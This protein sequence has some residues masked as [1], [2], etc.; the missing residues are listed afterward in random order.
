[1]TPLS[2]L[3]NNLIE[4]ASVQCEA[5]SLVTSF[6]GK[7]LYSSRSFMGLIFRL[8]TSKEKRTLKVERA[9]RE[10][11]E[12]FWNVAGEL[13]ECRT[14]YQLEKR[15]KFNKEIYDL[16]ALEQAEKV[17]LKA[18]MH[19]KP[20]FKCAEQNRP[21]PLLQFL[22]TG[23]EADQVRNFSDL[24]GFIR[25]LQRNKN[26]ELATKTEIPLAPLKKLYE[27]RRLRA[28]EEDKIKVWMAKVCEINA[29]PTLSQRRQRLFKQCTPR[30]VHRYLNQLTQYLLM[31]NELEHFSR[32]GHFE[33]KLV[34]MGF[35]LLAGEDEEHLAWRRDL[36]EGSVLTHGGGEVVLGEELPPPLYEEEG[37]SR[38]FA[39]QGDP[40]REVVVYRNESETFRYNRYLYGLHS[41]IPMASTFLPKHFG[42]WI[43]RERLRQPITEFDWLPNGYKKGDKAKLQTIIDLIKSL[44]SHKYTPLPFDRPFD[45]SF[46]QFNAQGEMR[47]A[48]PMVQDG[49]HFDIFEEIIER[50][51][52]G[53]YHVRD[54]LIQNSGLKKTKKI[55]GYQKLVEKVLKGGN[56]EKIANDN[57]KIHLPELIA[58]RLQLGRSILEARETIQKEILT[59]YSSRFKSGK[60]RKLLTKKILDIYK[61]D[62]YGFHLH[63]KFKDIIKYSFLGEYKE[64]FKTLLR[65]QPKAP[66]KRKK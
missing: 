21:N 36:K 50:C 38:V 7:T 65:R 8:F 6:S 15:K 31:R 20:L 56:L 29:T 10:T 33:E 51:S 57:G 14:T 49:R 11:V 23:R 4:I 17:M 30:S 39:I 13:L 53:H 28:K 24:S 42:A 61:K 63:E 32:F 9:V 22:F 27:L 48:Y 64:H 34:E 43:F 45:A 41:G 35:D 62:G 3:R 25:F 47:A 52:Q 12:K 60:I 40:A 5:S 37:Q 16:R 18:A 55:K 2:A 19:F 59:T 58:R 26:F 54:Y 44:I 66:K 46:F 1:M